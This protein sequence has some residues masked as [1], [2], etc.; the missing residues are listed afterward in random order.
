MTFIQI[1]GIDHS[2]LTQYSK[3][4]SVIHSSQYKAY[5]ENRFNVVPYQFDDENIDEIAYN[6]FLF[7][8]L[9]QKRK[10]I[11]FCMDNNLVS[12][13]KAI[14]LRKKQTVE[15]LFKQIEGYEILNIVFILYP[16]ITYDRFNDSDEEW[17]IHYGRMVQKR[18]EI[19]QASYM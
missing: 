10:A 5:I 14:D 12:S 16:S 8:T 11:K 15:R 4:S 17:G 2:K 6:D 19:E 9:R 18:I 13:D 1:N 7:Y 3:E